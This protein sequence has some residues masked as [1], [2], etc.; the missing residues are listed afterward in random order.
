MRRRE[1]GAAFTEVLMVAGILMLLWVSSSHLR[2]GYARRLQAL[3]LAESR[4]WERVFGRCG[5]EHVHERATL[6]LRTTQKSG[7]L[8]GGRVSAGAYFPCNQGGHP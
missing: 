7:L 3:S 2:A 5:G 1:R 8:L 4:T 6:D